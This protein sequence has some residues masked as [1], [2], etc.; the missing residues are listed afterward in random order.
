MSKSFSQAVRFQQR[1]LS[2]ALLLACACVQAQPFG[3]V[4]NSDGVDPSMSPDTLYRINLATGEAVSIGAT[5]FQDIEA[6]AFDENGQLYGVDDASNTL[7]RMDAFSGAG[8]RVGGSENNL[9]LNATTSFDFGM[10][11]VCGST[12]PLLTSDTTNQVFQLDLADNG[13][14]QEIGSFGDVS[15]TGLAS[16]VI[17][18]EFRIYGIGSGNINP[19]LYQVD[20]ESL[21]TS[22]V[23]PLAGAASYNDAGLAFDASGNL[24]AITDRTAVNGQNSGSQI[25]SIDLNSGTASIVAETF[26]GIESLAITALNCSGI[27]DDEDDGGPGDPDGDPEPEAQGVPAVTAPALVV[28]LAIMLMLAGRRLKH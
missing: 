3:F 22:L 14:A 12:Q 20:P 6:L 27:I 26:T 13:R 16:A 25:L 1:V 8:I 28:L 10:T 23:S 21:Q 4:V 17:D 18:G 11:F 19:G 9:G 5:G 7:L 15:L 24:W 2:C